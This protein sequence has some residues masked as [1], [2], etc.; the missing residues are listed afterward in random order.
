[1]YSMVIL[2]AVKRDGRV[3]PFDDDRIYNAI[4]KALENSAGG[5]DEGLADFLAS[6]VVKRMEEDC[7][8]CGVDSVSVE[9][10]HEQVERV[11]MGS[12]RKDAAQEYIRYRNQ[13]NMARKADSV[14]IFR[15]IVEAQANEI[16]RENANMNA[17]TPAG[18]MMKF[19][20]E[21]SKT[22]VDE[23]LLSPEAAAARR[24]LSISTTRTTI[25]PSPLPAS[26]TRLTSF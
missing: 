8:K 16:T 14:Q 22:F 10:I 3:V 9:E 18:M 4:S 17:D 23:C 15:E 6:S 25:R 24:T 19:A 5:P 26:S 2:N 11:L 21:A 1:M 13:R 20:S 12:V 7:A